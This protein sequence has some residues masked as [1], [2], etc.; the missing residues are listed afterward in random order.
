VTSLSSVAA[1]AYLLAPH[2]LTTHSSMI[3][4]TLPADSPTLIELAQATGVFKPIEIKALGEVLD[5][6][7]STN[8]AHGHRAITFEQSGQNMGFA[9]YALPR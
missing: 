1:S 9:Y 2:L 7:H 8:H 6:Y 3:R 4:P 5:D